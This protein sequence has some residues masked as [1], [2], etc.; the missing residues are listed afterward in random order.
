M[1]HMRIGNHEPLERETGRTVAETRT[2]TKE[3]E[4]K[5]EESTGRYISVLR[6]LSESGLPSRRKPVPVEALWPLTKS[7]RD[8]RPLHH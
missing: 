4:S 5:R 3:R 7:H 8:H 6:T 1:H 2:E